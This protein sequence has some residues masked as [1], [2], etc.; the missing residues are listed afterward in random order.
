MREKKTISLDWPFEHNGS[1]VTSF[2]MRA[3]TVGDSMAA[4]C[5]SSRDAE[6]EVHLI[7]SLCE[8]DPSMIHSVDLSDY[9]KLQVALADF[10]KP[11]ADASSQ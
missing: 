4:E 1:N 7:A 3:P 2:T 10:M 6:Q 9:G 11:R 8:V 5:T